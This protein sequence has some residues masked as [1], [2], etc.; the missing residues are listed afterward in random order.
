[1]IYRFFALVCE[2]VKICTENVWMVKF[3]GFHGVN[4]SSKEILL[5]A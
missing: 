4:D 2:W 5:F 3:I 1:M